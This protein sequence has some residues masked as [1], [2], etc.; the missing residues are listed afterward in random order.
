[1][2]MPGMG[3]TLN[4]DDCRKNLKSDKKTV[5]KKGLQIELIKAG[6]GRQHLEK[7][8][9]AASPEKRQAERFLGTGPTEGS[10]RGVREMPGEQL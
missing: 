2:Q 1:M 6:L 9:L 10:A 3:Q 5:T 4:T 7:L 8:S